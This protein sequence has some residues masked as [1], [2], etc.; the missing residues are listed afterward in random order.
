MLGGISEWTVRAWLSQGRL[1]RTKVG[2]R[3]MLKKDELNKVVREERICP[4]AKGRR[5]DQQAQRELVDGK[6]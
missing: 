4:A 5:V 3:T 2:R 6:T 1:R